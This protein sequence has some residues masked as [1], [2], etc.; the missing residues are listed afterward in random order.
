MSEKVA[1]EDLPKR[2]KRIP[3]WEIR[4]D[5]LVRSFEFDDFMEG[6]DFINGVADIAEQANH[7]PDIIVRYTTVKLSLITHDCGAISDRDFE[8]ASRIDTL[9]D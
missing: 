2:L 6:I 5:R 1:K 9:V 7:H 8:L 3:E 4:K